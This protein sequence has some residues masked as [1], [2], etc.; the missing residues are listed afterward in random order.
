V[1]PPVARLSSSLTSGIP[2]VT[3]AI[4][5]LVVAL[6]AVRLLVHQLVR[7]YI[8]T[9]DFD[10][11]IAVLIRSFHS[12]RPL[13]RPAFVGTFHLDVQADSLQCRGPLRREREV[14]RLALFAS[15]RAFSDP[16]VGPPSLPPLIKRGSDGRQRQRD[17]HCDAHALDTRIFLLDGWH[18]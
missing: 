14:R 15:P 16:L 3:D 11:R 5:R 9:A 2:G 6:L 4:N 1:A 18:P 12:I 8:A 17:R 7:R 13:Q 10:P